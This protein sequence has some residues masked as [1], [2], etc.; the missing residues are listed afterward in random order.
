MDIEAFTKERLNF[1]RFFY[2]EGVKPFK[3]IISLIENKQSP[4]DPVYDESGEPQF[5]CE[6]IQA[7]DGINAVGL[8]TVSMLSSALQL[9]M[10]GWLDR[11]ESAAAQPAKRT[12][13]KGGWFHALKGAMEHHGVDFTKCPVDLDVL[14]QTV[15]A[16]NRIQH[17]DDITSISI[18]HLKDDLGRFQ[19]P[20]FVDPTDVA[21]TY[22]WFDW[23]K[24]HVDDEV[25]TKVVC[26]VEEICTWLEAQHFN[27][28]SEPAV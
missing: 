2:L 1:A 10:K 11:T 22:S 5:I 13:C 20:V 16:R 26:A 7:Q 23:V 17:S 19:S 18:K 28:N 21:L 3:E 24:V 8:A 4:Y 12:G 27:V 25:F 15:L 6:W 14:E 9:Y